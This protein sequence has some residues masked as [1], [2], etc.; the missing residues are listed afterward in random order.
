MIVLTLAAFTVKER[1]APPLG[2]IEPSSYLAEIHGDLHVSTGGEAKFGLVEAGGGSPAVFTLS[3]G[4]SGS[5]GPV[6]FTR[7]N[8]GRLEPGTYFIG[9]R[10]DG[11]EEIVALVM[12]GTAWRPTGVFRGRSGYLIVTSASDDV[13]RGRFRV[14]GMGFLASNPEDE[15][16]PIRATGM[17]T[18]TRQ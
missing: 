6:L 18:A 15:S 13:I 7:T 4:A 3:L 17:F 16:R 11:S 14:E 12:T 8:G 5:D 10:D 1:P 2:S 9:G